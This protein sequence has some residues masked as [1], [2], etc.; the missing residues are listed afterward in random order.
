MTVCCPL[1]SAALV[2]D[3]APAFTGTVASTVWSFT[4]STVPVGVPASLT[5]ATDALKVT[6]CAARGLSDD[7]AS[8]VLVLAT[9]GPLSGKPAS[10]QRQRLAKSPREPENE[11][12]DV[13]KRSEKE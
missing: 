5:G 8:V 9:C 3:A 6:A 10:R 12:D 11:S 1:E 7:V 13:V 2:N 4:N